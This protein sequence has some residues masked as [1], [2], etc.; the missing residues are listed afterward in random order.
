MQIVLDVVRHGYMK[1][2][3]FNLMI[4]DECHNAQKDHPMVLLMAKFNEYPDQLHPR[5]IG[6]TGML[7]APS[8]KP[9]NVLSDLQNLEARFRATIKTAQGDSFQDVLIHST[10]PTEKVIEYEKYL[11]SDFHEFLDRRIA[12]MT[13]TI[14]EWPLDETGEGL[15]DR[16]N[17]KQPKIQKKFETICKEFMY[18]LGSLGMYIFNQNTKT[19]LST[20]ILKKNVEFHF[21]VLRWCFGQFGCNR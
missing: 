13:K 7:T 16:R 1:I 2:T 14:N 10:C 11:P 6:L 4:F 21:R 19:Q 9:G 3:D 5:V 8:I 20:K 17:E 15:S 12:K 18:Q